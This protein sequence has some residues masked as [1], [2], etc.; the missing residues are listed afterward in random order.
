EMAQSC[1][2]FYEDFA[3]FDADAAKKHLRPVARQPLEVVRDK[4][5]AI[6]EWTAE[7]V[8]HAIQATADEL[9]V[10]MGKVGMPLRVAVTGA[11]QSPALD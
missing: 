9:E 5:A 2:Y 3:E 1:R 7:N 6:S 10:G 8:H 11:G 4:L